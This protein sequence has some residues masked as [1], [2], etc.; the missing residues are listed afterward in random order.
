MG[1]AAF[2]RDAGR[3]RYPDTRALTPLRVVLP[4]A[5]EMGAVRQDAPGLMAE[6]I[7]LPDKVVAHVVPDFCQR[8]AVGRTEFGDVRRVDNDLASVGNH[9]LKFVHTL[10]GGPHILVHFRYN[11]NYLPCE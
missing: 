1:G 5:G 9:R 3:Q 10:G 11:R 7:P 2:W 4:A 8:C 6:A